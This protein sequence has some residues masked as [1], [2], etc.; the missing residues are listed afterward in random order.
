[1]LTTTDLL[2]KLLDVCEESKQAYGIDYTIDYYSSLCAFSLH[3]YP[4]GFTSGEDNEYV[5]VASMVALTIENT[6]DAVTKLTRI[7]CSKKGGE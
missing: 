2:K 7:C 1:M 6:V 4:N 3:V 5:I